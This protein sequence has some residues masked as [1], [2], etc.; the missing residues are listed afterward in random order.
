M[1]WLHLLVLTAILLGV[2][3]HAAKEMHYKDGDVVPII[4]NKVG[5]F[6]NPTETYKYYDMPYCRP[7]KMKKQSHGLGEILSGDRK[8]ISAYVVYFKKDVPMAKL[9]SHKLS[10]EDVE[11]F[12]K[13]VDEEY[14]FE[15]FMDSLPTWGYIGDAPT[16]QDL[17]LPD[18][19]QEVAEGKKYI[20][21]HIHFTVKYNGDQIIEWNATSDRN[22]RKDIT[23]LEPTEV[24]FTY[25]VKWLPTTASYKTR[26]D[27]YRNGK[28]LPAT[29][30]IHW[31]SII[32]SF[33]LVV[34]LMVF[35]S[36]ILMRVLKN[37]FTRYMRVD[38][39]EDFAEEE[40]GWKLIHGDV[41]RFPENKMLFTALLG[42]GA[43]L[44]CMVSMLLMLM[45]FSVVGVQRGAIQTAIIFLY[46]LTAGIG[47]YVSARYYKQLGGTN[48]VWNTVLCALLFPGPFMCMFIFLNSVADY[49][50][51]T[52]ALPVGTILVIFALYILV[53]FPLT[54]FGGILGRNRAPAFEAPCRTMKVPRQIPNVPWYRHVL[55]QMFMAGFL[56]FSAIYIELHYIFASIWGH[57]IYTLFG[58][59]FLAFIMLLAVTSFITVALTYF[60]LASEDHRW[61][62]R[63]LF[64]GGSTGLF[65]YAYCFFYYY[66][67]SEMSGMLQTSFFFGYML[68]VS[69]AFFM[70][71]GTV[72]FFSALFFVRHIYKA[73]KA[74]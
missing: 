26:M 57:K 11:K 49:H 68:M 17:L 54:V 48:W 63:S 32:N 12:H 59:L 36:I 13:A 6:S 65:V 52:A 33:V 53:T 71:L 45:L 51:S 58:I 10:V 35:L 70:L 28:L 25:S 8:V 40:T 19:L 31:L 67:R 60:Q 34:L 27:K 20:F 23:A 55:T 61:W 46:A 1:K 30:E 16:A 69:Y 2:Q 37:D 9:C 44:F 43:Q 38:E 56:P 41:F 62:W 18:H 39:E 4:A 66:N 73:I 7:D 24:D 5:P 22:S 64:Y 74:E 72:G 29:F 14:F 50:D 3:V 42:S 15:L 21:P 47:G